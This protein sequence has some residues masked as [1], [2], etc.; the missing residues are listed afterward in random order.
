MGNGATLKSTDIHNGNERETKR[1]HTL[2]IVKEGCKCLNPSNG[3]RE[4]LVTNL[5]NIHRS[6]GLNPLI[7][8]N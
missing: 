5:S 3:A 7:T 1:D 6:F 2:W 4:Q 8:C